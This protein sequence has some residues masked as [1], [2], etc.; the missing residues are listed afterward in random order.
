MNYA[1]IEEIVKAHSKAIE[2]ANDMVVN[3]L[4]QDKRQNP[5]K[6]VKK[7]I[8]SVEDN[9][10]MLNY[11]IETNRIYYNSAIKTVQKLITGF[12][13]DKGSK[14]LL[15]IASKEAG[16]NQTEIENR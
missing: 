5:V 7:G 1:N 15:F 13:C 9:S 4:S 12:S 14:F 3:I 11:I 6:E 16:G 8:V 2:E 10:S